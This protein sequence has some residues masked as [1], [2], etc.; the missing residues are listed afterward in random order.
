MQ[1]NVFLED[2]KELEL[3]DFMNYTDGSRGNLGKDIPVTV[4]R[5]LEYSLREQLLRQF[6]KETQVQVFQ[7]AGFRAGVYFAEN[8]LNLKLPVN[9]FIS[10]LQNKMEEFRIGVL[11]IEEMDPETGRLVLTVAEDA[12]CS[13]MPLL[14]D[15]VCNYDEGFLAGVLTTYTGKKYTAKEIDCWATGDR[16][17]RFRAEIKE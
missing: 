5:L 8:M 15:T 6:G 7:D 12:D 1:D 9:A 14:G 11:R 17:C 13:G 10:D 4:Y 16:L 3:A 2:R